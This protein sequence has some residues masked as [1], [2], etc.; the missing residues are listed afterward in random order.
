MNVD[1]TLALLLVAALAAATSAEQP[2]PGVETGI[3][4]LR[5]DHFR[6]L[7]GQRVG[8]VTNQTGRAAD[9][10]PTSA[11]LHAADGV[12][13]VALF[14]PEH[15]IDGKQDREGIGDARD[16]RT[17]LPIHSLYGD[18]R[19][20]TREQLAEIDTLVFDIQDIGTRF[21]T[22]VS[23]LGECLSAAA[24]HRKR[25]VVLDRPNPLGGEVVSGPVLDRGKNSFVGWHPIA[26]RHGMTLGELAKM[27][28]AERELAVT[29][30]VVQCRNWGR[31]D[32]YDATGLTWV[33]P[34][35]NMR[36]LTAAMLYPGVGLLET[37]N[38]SVGRGTDA[39][40]EFVGAPWIDGRKW[41]DELRAAKLP[42]VSFVPVDFTPAES[43]FRGELCQGVRILLVDWRQHDA[44]RL[45]W[46]LATSLRR[47]YPQAWKSTGYNR[48][49]GNDRVYNAILS[50]E[51]PSGV[52][53]IYADE[54]A[55][56]RQRRKVFLL[57]D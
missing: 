9:G 49:L 46:E 48:L 52:E 44:T 13:L 55:A 19:R 35:P 1:S 21:Y 51:R 6:S 2:Q 24:E 53:A 17:G 33:N 3:D 32:R 27:F 22:Y 39:P 23:T 50:A 16:D 26:I 54:L 28:V 7:R 12:R 42:G 14:S 41:A 57:Y 18:K 4:V 56:F 43:K 8:L 37:T 5:K 25:I 40:F 47:L 30:E 11:I 20:P 38:V 34:S 10:T 31:S 15:G 36:S 29:L 45:G